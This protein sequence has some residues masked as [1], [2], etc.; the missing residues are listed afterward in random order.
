[1]SLIGEDIRQ[2]LPKGGQGGLPPIDDDL[3][4]SKLADE[5]MAEFE[6]KSKLPPIDED[7]EVSKLA[8]ELMAERERQ[9][10]RS[11]HGN[12]V[13]ID[14]SG[15]PRDPTNIGRAAGNAY[16]QYLKQLGEAQRMDAGVLS[17]DIG[18]A[19]TA[20]LHEIMTMPGLTPGEQTLAVSARGAETLGDAEGAKRS[21]NALQ[22]RQEGIQSAGDKLVRE[23]ESRYNQY[24]QPDSEF[25]KW[26]LNSVESSGMTVASGLLSGLA[27]ALGGPVAGGIAGLLSKLKESRIEAG[28]AYA[29]GKR[30]G[31]PPEQLRDVAE[32]TQNYNLALLLATDP[33][34]LATFGLDKGLGKLAQKITGN[35]ILSRLGRFATK[36]VVPYVAEGATEYPEGFGQEVITQNALGDPMDLRKAHEAG[37][38]EG[39]GALLYTAVGRGTRGMI[40]MARRGSSGGGQ[41]VTADPARTTLKSGRIEDAGDWEEVVSATEVPVGEASEGGNGGEGDSGPQKPAFQLRAGRDDAAVLA[42][43]F[44]NI[45]GQIRPTIDYEHD[46]PNLYRQL[47][48]DKEGNTANA[49]NSGPVDLKRDGVVID[50]NVVGGDVV[51][52]APSQVSVEPPPA[53][54]QE[55]AIPAEE[56]VKNI[57]D[58]AVQQTQEGVAA[59]AANPPESGIDDSIVER[60]ARIVTENDDASP[61]LLQ[62][63]LKIE[64]APAMALL[65]ELEKRGIVS[66]PGEG[67]R[68]VVPQ[69]LQN[70]NVER[71]GAP[72]EQAMP[73]AAVPTRA[74][75]NTQPLFDQAERESVSS[76]S[77]RKTLSAIRDEIRNKT[78]AQIRAEY[79]DEIAAKNGLDAT[80]NAIAEKKANDLVAPLAEEPKRSQTLGQTQKQQSA[81]E[82][83]V[84]SEIGENRTDAPASV[85]FGKMTGKM[86]AD[87]EAAIRDAKVGELIAAGESRERAE[88]EATVYARAARGAATKRRMSP[89]EWEESR[90][91][92]V[93]KGTAGE[94]GT[95]GETTYDQPLNPD[96]DPNAEVDVVSLKKGKFPHLND[97]ERWRYGKDPDMKRAIRNIASGIM[98]K[99]GEGVRN[100]HHPDLVLTLSRG[101][102]DHVIDTAIKAEGIEGSILRRSVEYLDDLARNAYRV[103]TSRDRYKDEGYTPKTGEIRAVHRFLVPVDY[104]GNAYVLQMTVKE[105]E[106]GT[107]EIG[108]L[109]LYDQKVAKKMPASLPQDV[110]SKNL[111]AGAVAGT[112]KVSVG[113]LSRGV[114]TDNTEKS[115]GAGEK[116]FDSPE[117]TRQEP[118]RTRLKTGA[119]DSNGNIALPEGHGKAEDRGAAET[120]GGEEKISRRAGQTGQEMPTG[121]PI[122]RLDQSLLTEKGSVKSGKE[123]SDS[124]RLAP[125]DSSD[126]SPERRLQ[127]DAAR[128]GDTV[129]EILAGKLDNAS[130]VHVMTTPLVFNLV[131]ARV[132]PVHMQAGKIAKI[133]REHGI[134][135]RLLK[136]I[137]AALADPIAIL[138]S[139]SEG[140][141]RGLV[142]MLE[143]KD[144]RGA[145][146]VAAMHMEVTPERKGLT[147]NRLASV[148][149]KGNSGKANDQWF[150]S[151]IEKGNLRYINKQKSSLWLGRAGIKFTG[152][153]SLE[154]FLGLNIPT[155]KDLVKLK[156]QH[157]GNYR[158][159]MRGFEHPVTLEGLRRSVPGAKIADLGDGKYRIDLHNGESIIV[160]TVKEIP[161]DPD[162]VRRDYGREPGAG[163]VVAG[164]S[165]TIDGGRFIDLVE[166]IAGEGTFDHEIFETARN[167]VLTAEEKGILDKEIG[168]TEAQ[169]EAYREFQVNRKGAMTGRIVRVFQKLKDFFGAIRSRLFGKNSADIFRE[170]AQGKVWGREAERTGAGAYSLGAEAEAGLNEDSA[171]FGRAVDAFVAGNL[172]PRQPIPVM[173]TP[174][175]LHLA[176]ADVVPMDIPHN[177]L[178]KVF[179]EH[180]LSPQVVKQIPKA[181]AD[182]VMVFQSDSRADS[183]VVLLEIRDPKRGSVV[184]PVA[185]N[186]VIDSDGTTVNQMTSVY[187]REKSSGKPQDEWIISQIEKGNLRYIDKQKSSAWDTLS[188]QKLS[189]GTNLSTWMRKQNFSEQNIHTEEDLVKA[190]EQSRTRYSLTQKPSGAPQEWEKIRDKSGLERV[191]DPEE[192]TMSSME[193]VNAAKQWWDMEMMDDISAVKKYFGEEVYMRVVNAL[194]GI[195]S[196]AQAL[197]E[198]GDKEHGV[199]SLYD[200]FG[201]LPAEEHEGLMHYCVFR[202][203]L[204]ISGSS[205]GAERLMAP[206]KQSAK[207]A[208]EKAKE[209]E[210]TMPTDEFHHRRL[211]DDAKKAR[212]TAQNYEEQV[213]D[214]QLQIKTTRGKASQ[215]RAAVARLEELY[216]HWKQAQQDLVGFSRHL[217]EKQRDAGVVSDELYSLLTQKYPNYIPLQR[218]FGPDGDLE[219]SMIR[220]KGIVNLLSPIKRLKGSKRNVIDPLYQIVANAYTV[221]GLVGKQAAAREIVRMVD[222]GD[223]EGLIDPTDTPWSKPGEYV[224]HVWE[225]GKKR[226]FRT[227]PDIYMALVMST[228]P[229]IDGVL[230]K[231]IQAPVKA[232]REGVTHGPGFILRNPI[233]DTIMAG[234]VG[235]HFVPF[236]DTLRGVFHVWKQDAVFEEF[237]RSGAMQGLAHLDPKSRKRMAEMIR[238]G[239][240]TE[241]LTDE[242]RNPPRALWRALGAASALSE[243]GTRVGQY[244]KVRQYG[245]SMERAA[246]VS[247]D[248]LNYMRGG[249]TSKWASRYVPFFNASVQ[250]VSKGLRAIYH[251][252]K[253]DAGTLARGV[254]YITVPSL[255]TTI[256]NLS[257]DDRRKKYLALPAWR[258]NLFWNIFVGEHHFM[259]PKPFELGVVFGS[260][261]ERF[262]DWLFANDRKAFDGMATSLYNAVMPEYMP[263]FFSLPLELNANYSTFYERNI[264]PLS[265]TRLVPKLQYGAYTSEWAKWAGE[266]FGLSPRKLEYAVLQLTGGSGK[267]VSNLADKA[268][269]AVE[270]ETRPARD[271]YEETPG[272]SSFVSRARMGQRWT[273]MF[274]DER[275][276]IDTLFRSAKQIYEN[277][278]RGALTLQERRILGAE[279]GIRQVNQLFT[280]KGGIDD[281]RREISKVTIAK[282]MSAEEKRARVDRLEAKIGDLSERGLAYIDRIRKSMNRGE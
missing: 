159:G 268:F 27:W 125:E 130:S 99:F 182:P 197:I 174:L 136:Q 181:M 75:A 169:A 272:V 253:V 249:R 84:A 127:I 11:E 138:E 187:F 70:R 116:G 224:F 92:R 185:L 250:G 248:I 204:D 45:F 242:L 245:G 54:A 32:K 160:S 91:A 191:N 57:A 50:T 186:R 128:F 5:L 122:G 107:R 275:E 17:Y 131:G 78:K 26:F 231:I 153:A 218:D 139:D 96:V 120:G 121:Q 39:T 145:T 229:N 103:K 241:R 109:A 276:E 143:L 22:E 66:P 1:M 265:Q 24:E 164:A 194:H 3:E 18:K 7:P 95:K 146:I 230:A 238:A 240:G 68:T 135:S 154:S 28:G 137:P 221:E 6:K 48:P 233:R 220:S 255:L 176:G 223:Y 216:P 252:G 277:S 256:W 61:E 51:P 56:I 263:L 192:R 213:A 34:D 52:A 264:V 266:K 156:E 165:R 175:A 113:E 141:Y 162:V 81:S 29:E 212:K 270:D 47:F 198:F 129:D 37:M 215:Y 71:L 244:Q 214:L 16:A 108:K 281:L 49:Q 209:L 177:V 168:S 43:E 235:E 89:L 189:D 4:V 41:S 142:A 259:I 237:M 190:R 257:D 58:A 193:R 83:P 161:M 148:Y 124:Y 210:T 144:E 40:D 12:N 80:A 278:G 202:H 200:I 79:G 260:I 74:Q 269:R 203:L 225:G 280:N 247:R 9:I 163:E 19:Q 208:T 217:L 64:H 222:R 219:G 111:V 236:V 123:P 93:R 88:A 183:V 72:S 100:I 232:L 105:M 53:V 117:A 188:G 274:A 115:P 55:Q 126:D 226:Y 98:G 173:T 170:I 69:P 67:G 102:I 179:E 44:P 63:R 234:V 60:A 2:F 90:G 239:K 97:S 30:R 133:M 112:G 134:S 149:G 172:N 228:A 199:R 211:L 155:E 13:P 62:E 10:S 243:L 171:K 205:E 180:S 267:D 157:P 166:G 147:V 46:F 86:L 21:W 35:G 119:E 151:Q 42:E 59:P 110:D 167:M 94:S 261:P 36:E 101:G 158:L 196:R 140:K 85:P 65:D 282:G 262:A 31:M 8:D 273:Q 38:M 23:G 254:L 82:S 258:R 15:L 184:V 227:T 87:E 201:S 132:L 279:N 178:K 271:W 114:K 152:G 77:P 246:F 195:N 206:L 73:E 118:T 25:W 207:E 20:P 14:L 33:L 76:P 104:E 106:N 251:D 150:A